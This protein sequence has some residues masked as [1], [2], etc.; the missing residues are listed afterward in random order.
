MKPDVPS[1]AHPGSQDPAASFAEYLAARREGLLEAW[2]A[3]VTADP[4]LTSSDDLSRNQF[5][6]HIPQVLAEFESRL[7]EEIHPDSTP[8]RADHSDASVEHGGH[9]WEQGYDLREVILEWGH[10]HRCLLNE[11]EVAR[12]ALPHLGPEVFFS[13]H[14]SLAA[15]IHM[16]IADSAEQFARLQQ[17]DAIRERDDLE[18]TVARFVEDGRGRATLWR[19]WTHDLR[20]QLSIITS[21][22]SLLEDPALE[23]SLRAESLEMLQKGT[24][25]LK[26]MLS[27]V[28]EDTRMET[29]REECRLDAFDAGTLL[30]GLCAASLPLARERGLSLRSNGPQSLAVE[31]DRGKVQ[32]IAQNLLLN[33]LSYT[34]AGGVTLSWHANEPDWWSFQVQDTGPGLPAKDS[35]LQGH[36]SGQPPREGLGLSIVRRLCEL[37]GARLHIETAPGAG[38][39]FTI[40][41]PRR[42]AP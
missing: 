35:G 26:A 39:T 19:E 14:R 20:G 16:A 27:G 25:T 12:V 22:T 4:E 37:L 31:G 18:R 42:Y 33:A 3:A 32:R 41:L 29:S 7:L 8:R 15:L 30:G 11:L 34:S 2:Q 10:L 38:T 17:K 9:R 21:A 5:R 36:G 23:E 24:S 40:T 6:D 13:A 1:A 28:L